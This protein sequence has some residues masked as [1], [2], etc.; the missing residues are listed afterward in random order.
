MEPA[1]QQNSYWLCAP[2]LS[3][4][5]K[6]KVPSETI[7]PTI[8]EKGI[9]GFRLC[10]HDHLTN[11]QIK[12]L[13]GIHSMPLEQQMTTV[14]LC[15]PCADAGFDEVMIKVLVSLESLLGDLQEF[16][17]YLDE[18]AES[19][20]ASEI[21]SNASLLRFQKR[22]FE[23]AK[24]FSHPEKIWAEKRALEAL[25]CEREKTSQTDRSLALDIRIT[26]IAYTATNYMLRY[27][28]LQ[29]PE[30]VVNLFHGCFAAIP[31]IC[32]TKPIEK[33][34]FIEKNSPFL[35]FQSK[36]LPGLALL[37]SYKQTAKSSKRRK[38]Y[39]AAVL[40]KTTDKT[41]RCLPTDG[42]TDKEP[43]RHKRKKILGPDGLNVE[44]FERLLH[45]Q[46]HITAQGVELRLAR[47]KT[48]R[49]QHL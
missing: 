36:Q 32:P 9:C 19:L 42:Y 14:E 40:F 18:S 17:E 41:N 44:L 15:L 46:S 31:A 45:G 16:K 6:E 2:K 48:K 27:N 28:R 38:R 13:T 12:D 20:S 35:R 5:E 4:E 3:L 22:R 24:D 29:Y 37:I 1:R 34:D 39:A 43:S 26:Q 11:L 47:L 7:I 33:A 8:A 10:Q 30:A 25:A 21:A 49:K 23:L